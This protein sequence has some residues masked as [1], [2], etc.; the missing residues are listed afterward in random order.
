MKTLLID[1]KSTLP[2]FNLAAEEYFLKKDGRDKLILWQNEPSVIIGRNQNTLAEINKDVAD[3]MGIHVV[4]RM[5]GGGAV[6]HDLGNL[7]YTFITKNVGDD[8]LNFKKFTDPVVDVLLSLGVNATLS[9]RNDLLIDGRKFS[10]N[11]QYVYKDMLLHHGTLMFKVSTDIL[12]KV[13]TVNEMKIKTKGIASVKSRVTN[14]SGYSDISIPEFKRLVF[15]A[16]DGEK[17]TLA[18]EDIAEIKKLE[19]EKYA[20][21]EWN[22]GFSPKYSY[23]NAAHFACGIIELNMDIKNG[24]IEKA[25][26]SGDFFGRMDSAPIA[27]ALCGVHHE[28]K[29]IRKTLEKFPIFEYFAGLCPDDLIILF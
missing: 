10:G 14:I 26:F 11:A 7:N 29:E 5:S 8:F 28:E 1:L 19:K 24:I 23:H 21:W 9:G 2:Q 18:D 4:R 20:T 22:Y 12:E 6:F 25:L 17:Y 27:E 15:D 13:L 3:E 16:A